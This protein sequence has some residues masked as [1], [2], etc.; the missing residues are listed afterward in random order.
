MIL[1]PFLHLK[2]SFSVSWRLALYSACF[3]SPWRAR[4]DHLPPDSFY[5]LP[6]PASW[7][8]FSL[9]FLL[10]SL[11][12]LSWLTFC[13][14][15][16][17]ICWIFYFYLLSFYSSSPPPSHHRHRPFSLS[18]YFCYS[19]SCSSSFPFQPL[20]SCLPLPQ[21]PGYLHHPIPPPGPPRLH[22]PP[23]RRPRLPHQLP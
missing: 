10:F 22:R 20:P 15:S 18:F 14:S 3:S 13:S 7:Q 4:T 21:H 6:S 12:F 1:L 23:L 2:P 8:P 16:P 9:F 11:S 19:S 17:W 5:L